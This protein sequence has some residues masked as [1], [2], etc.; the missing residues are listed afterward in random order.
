MIWLE[1]ISIRAAGIIEA[2]KVLNACG[3]F[4]LSVAS[5]K[6]LK[7]TIFRNVKYATDISIHL[8]WKS[9]PGNESILGRQ[10]SSELENHGLVSH[11]IWIQE[12]QPDG[13]AAVQQS[14]RLQV[15]GVLGP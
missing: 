1:M 7:M 13:N 5:D 3:H 6:L 8:Q 9:N 14:S 12:E 10:L 15:G 4:Y 2:E 11:T